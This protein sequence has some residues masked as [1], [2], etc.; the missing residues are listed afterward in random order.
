MHQE[1]DFVQVNCGLQDVATRSVTSL[2][3]ARTVDCD[4]CASRPGEAVAIDAS[5]P[6]FSA[7]RF[8]QSSRRRDSEGEIHSLR[9]E[10]TSTQND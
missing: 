1:D 3:N 6:A 10:F 5:S 9:L 4:T 8:H 2:Q 7:G